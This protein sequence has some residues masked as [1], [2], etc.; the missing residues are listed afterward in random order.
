MNYIFTQHWFNGSGVQQH[1]KKCINSKNKNK[2]LEI[3]SFEGQSSVFFADNLLDNNDSFLICV[4]PYIESGTVEG[5][6]T[7]FVNNDVKNRFTN[8]ISKSKNANKIIHHCKTS[9]DFFLENNITYN[10][11]YIDGCHNPEYVKRDINNAFKVLEKNGILWMDDYLYGDRKEHK[12]RP[13]DVI[14]QFLKE[15]IGK[16]EIIYKDYQIAIKKL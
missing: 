8:N 16:Y 13:Q 1:I 3:G 11:I 10:F 7:L 6:T 5:I 4:D 9:D 14:D 15:N 2:I 12:G